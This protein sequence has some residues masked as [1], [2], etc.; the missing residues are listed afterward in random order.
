MARDAL[1]SWLQRAYKIARMSVK[2][3][4]PPPEVQGFLEEQM[5]R[6]QVLYGGMAIATTLAANPQKRFGQFSQPLASPIRISNT[7]AKVLVVGAGIAGLTAAYHLRQAGIAVDVVEAT[8]RVGGRMRSITPASGASALRIPAAI[9]LGGEFLDTGH[10][11]LRS[12][13]ER[14]GLEIIDLQTADEGL[15]LGTFFFEGRKLDLKAVIEDFVPLARQIERDLESLKGWDLTYR[16]PTAEAIRLDQT[17]LADYLDAA[18]I[19]PS[20]NKLL[21]VAYTAEHGRNPEEQSCLNLLFMVGTKAGLWQV[22]GTSDERYHV[23]GGNEQIPQRLAQQVTNAIETGTVLESI[24]TASEGGYRVGLRQTLSSFERIY[25]RVVLTV[26]FTVLRQVD[27]EVDLPPTKR[28]AI[29]R[30]GYG[31]GTKLITPYRERIWRTRYS[32]TAAVFTDLSFQSAWEST[33]YAPGMGGWLASLTGGDRGLAIGSGSPEAHA[34]AMAAELEPIFPGISRMKQGRA[35]RAFWTG[36]PYQKGSY[37][38]YLVGQWTQLAGAESERVGNLW[39]AG[40]HCSPGA[41]GYM[42]GG[43]ETGR[44]AATSILQD[45]GMGAIAS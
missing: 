14:L 39:F 4:I 43:C 9:E 21:R 7:A 25:E 40:E 24:R 12:L 41:K 20:L 42:E 23:S 1:T 33:R 30:L 17:S 13:A 8:H 36:E 3:N 22:Y 18:P 38:C 26:P 35:L 16:S 6:R 11:H 2:T 28:L 19:S 45:L 29:D 5:S 15:E 27:L 37:S 44:A 31:T 34:W 32:S 10:T